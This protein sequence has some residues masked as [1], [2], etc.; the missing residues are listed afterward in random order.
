MVS[1]LGSI[2]S[3]EQPRPMR[4]SRKP[5]KILLWPITNAGQRNG[6]VLEIANNEKHFLP[7]HVCKKICKKFKREK[8]DYGIEGNKYC[9][10][11]KVFFKTERKHCLCCGVC[12]RLGSH[13]GRW[14]MSFRGGLHNYELYNYCLT[15]KL[16]YEKTILRCKECN[17]RVRSKPQTKMGQREHTRI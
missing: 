3:P 1:P 7:I 4:K 11:C 16:R 6:L 13:N 10:R 12:L 5:F 2:L 9:C 15:C 14:I 8:S 17:R